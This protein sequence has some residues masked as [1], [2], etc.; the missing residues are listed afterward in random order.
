MRPRLLAS[1]ALLDIASAVRSS[2]TISYSGI[3]A[4]NIT[5]RAFLFVSTDPDDEPRSLIGDGVDTQQL[6]GV[7]VA[8]MRAGDTAVIDASTLGY[9][10][11]SLDK[12]PPGAYRVQAV[13]QPYHLYRI[14]GAPP[15]WLPRTEVNRFEGGDIFTSPGTY[16]SKPVTLSLADSTASHDL[17][18][19]RQDAPAPEPPPPRTDTKYIKHVRITSKLL[20]DFWG[21]PVQLEACVLLPWGFAEHP[22]TSWP[23]FLY[24][25]HYHDD[26]AT[27][28]HFSETPAPSGL[29]GYDL[30]Q[31]QYAYE[32]RP[33]G[34]RSS[35]LTPI[36]RLD[37]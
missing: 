17:V 13:I 3:G 33:H 14:A 6:F 30:V 18:V 7:D 36:L 12:V 1:A 37:P 31:A 23:T 26:W 19:D 5:G 34:C 9:P 24:H 25:G 22:N 29:V 15:V 8:D 21:E 20:S 2:F 11:L 10:L 32:V 27:P 28:A 4:P 16:Y 35:P